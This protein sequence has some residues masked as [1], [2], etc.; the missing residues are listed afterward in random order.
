[1]VPRHPGIQQRFEELSD[2][3]RWLAH[4]ASGK[5][6]LGERALARK[7]LHLYEGALGAALVPARDTNP[8]AAARRREESHFRQFRAVPGQISPNRA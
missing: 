6:E 4:E 3:D 1:V 5:L 2:A 7:S 8:T